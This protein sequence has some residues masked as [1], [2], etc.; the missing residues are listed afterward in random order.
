MASASSVLGSPQGEG[1]D[2]AS[3]GFLPTGAADGNEKVY[4]R[5]TKDEEADNYL[6]SQEK[7]QVFSSG[8][9]VHKEL[10]KMLTKSGDYH[11]WRQSLSGVTIY[12]G[13]HYP[14]HEKGGGV[15]TYEWS[16]EAIVED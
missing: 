14:V 7:R 5:L 9:F 16:F 6:I 12:G 2:S 15:N 8:Y 3:A 10:G 13:R 4:V 1:T 11:E